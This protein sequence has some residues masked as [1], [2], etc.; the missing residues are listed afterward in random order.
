MSNPIIL[1]LQELK[2]F[3]SPYHPDNIRSVVS[4]SIFS[5]C[6][7][8]PWS[9]LPQLHDTKSSCCLMLLRPLQVLFALVRTAP[10]CVH[11]L[12]Q[13]PRSSTGL[14]GNSHAGRALDGPSKA[15][16]I[17]GHSIAESCLLC[18]RQ[19][20]QKPGRGGQTQTCTTTLTSSQWLWLSFPLKSKM[21]NMVVGPQKHAT[22][23][24]AVL[25]LRGR[26]LH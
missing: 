21:L 18:A 10:M 1:L 11:E 13:G 8:V 7:F 6:L 12:L 22:F 3:G 19:L 9:K 2:T 14:L 17:C 25:L 26:W 4:L 5:F 23:G 15:G 16:R 24:S 20:W